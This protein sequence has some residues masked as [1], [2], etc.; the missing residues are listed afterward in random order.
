MGAIAI[1]FL[2]MFVLYLVIWAGVRNGV[3]DA[4]KELDIRLEQQDGHTVLSVKDKEIPEEPEDG[5]I[6]A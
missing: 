4:I 5:K 3:K 2:T 1:W 6:L